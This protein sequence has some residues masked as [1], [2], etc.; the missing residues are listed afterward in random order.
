MKYQKN[1][2]GSFVLDNEGNPIVELTDEE[3]EAAKDKSQLVDELKELRLK[4]GLMKDLLEKKEELPAPAPAAPTEDD[5]IISVIKKVLD[6]EK[7]SNAQAN[8]TAAFEKFV[9][10]H[11]EFNPENDSL[12]LKRNAL[13]KK[14]AQFNVTGLTTLDEFYTVIGDAKRLLTGNDNQ[15]TT[16][17]GTQIPNSQTPTP[18]PNPSGKK[19]DEL[20]PQ[21]LKLAEK[22]GRT[23]EQMLKIKLKHPDLLRDLLEHVRD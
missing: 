12:G 10:E 22:T 4:N 18:K 8:K 3:K 6:S 15:S 20:T 19:D 17:T 23:R 21:E 16:P 13:E 2:D 14:L 5:K 1:D 9:A 7:A 11:P